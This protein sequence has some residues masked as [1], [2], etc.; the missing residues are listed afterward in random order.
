V[1]ISNSKGTAARPFGWKYTTLKTISNMSS[2]RQL[3]IAMM[4]NP[5]ISFLFLLVVFFLT[6]YSVSPEA[7]YVCFTT[8]CQY[9][10]ERQKHLAKSIELHL[11][12][13]YYRDAIRRVDTCRRMNIN[14]QHAIIALKKF[15]E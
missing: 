7:D 15:R 6:V 9:H 3:A 12:L 13:E 4:T 14:V 5:N 1:D 11:L 10:K 8:F 2:V